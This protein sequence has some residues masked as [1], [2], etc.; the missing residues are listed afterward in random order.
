MHVP[1]VIKQLAVPSSYD[2][3]PIFSHVELGTG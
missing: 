3:S 1:A 2:D